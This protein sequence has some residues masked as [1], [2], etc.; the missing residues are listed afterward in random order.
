M[1][2]YSQTSQLMRLILYVIMYSMYMSPVTIDSESRDINENLQ[3]VPR[4]F[5]SEHWEREPLLGNFYITE[6]SEYFI[7]VIS[8]LHKILKHFFF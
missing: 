2:S 1:L 3:K 5:V 7:P 6:C 8:N 4:V